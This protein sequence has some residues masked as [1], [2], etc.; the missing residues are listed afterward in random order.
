MLRRRRSAASFPVLFFDR[1]VGTTFPR[2][3]RE[4]TVPTPIEF[5]QEHFA[6]DSP[7]D[8][9]MAEIGRKNWIVV[10]HDRRHH[11]EKAE[12]DAINL[13]SI[14]CFYLWGANAVKWQ[15]MR[16]F[17]RAYERILERAQ[18]AQKPFV[19]RVTEPGGL[20]DIQI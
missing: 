10:G 6:S 18:N 19:F 12:L 14:G 20:I 7:D 8:E 11:R 1:D 13:Y 16:C 5:H 17:L 4:L 2:A 15:K 3:L 9:W